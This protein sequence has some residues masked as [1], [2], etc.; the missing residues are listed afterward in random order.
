ML[1]LI[2]DNHSFKNRT[3]PAGPTGSTGNRPPIRSGYIK[4]PKIMKKPRNSKNRP[5]QPENREPARLKWFLTGYLFFLSFP[6]LKRRSFVVLVAGILIPNPKAHCPTLILRLSFS[7]FRLRLSNLNISASPKLT[8]SL[9]HR[10]QPLCLAAQT[11]P[12]PPHSLRLTASPV[13]ARPLRL[14][15]SV[16]RPLRLTLCL[17]FSA[18][19]SSPHTLSLPLCLALSASLKLTGLK[20]WVFFFFLGFFLLILTGSR[21]RPLK[22][23]ALCFSASSGKVTFFSFDFIT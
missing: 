15:A 10:S 11:S 14:T 1:Q 4:K 12:S 18:S 5:V 17:A 21:S 20:Y 19:P 6:S 22:C 16:P 7:F 2:C 9:P 3:G 13:A 8:A 23:S